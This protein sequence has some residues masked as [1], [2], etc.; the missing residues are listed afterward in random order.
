MERRTQT[1][2]KIKS[3]PPTQA[4]TPR[5]E[6]VNR[7]AEDDVLFYFELKLPDG[8]TKNIPIRKGEQAQ[9]IVDEHCSD[10]KELSYSTMKEVEMFIAQ[11]IELHHRR[12]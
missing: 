8:R 10:E 9:D 12:R 3:Q 1:E 4:R 6:V 11:K 2:T 5:R 7:E